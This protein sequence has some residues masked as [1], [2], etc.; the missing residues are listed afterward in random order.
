MKLSTYLMFEGN[1]REAFTHYEK[2][3][4]GKI[5]AMMDHK[6]TPAEEPEEEPA[7]STESE[8]L[9]EIRDL[10]KAQRGA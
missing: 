8:L 9:V 5:Q 4:G 1:C 10:L 7:A 6:G 2:V 3:L